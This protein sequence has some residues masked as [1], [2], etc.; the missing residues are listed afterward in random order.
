MLLTY[1]SVDNTLAFYDSMKEKKE[2]GGFPDFLAEYIQWIE[3]ILADYG[4][5]T[6]TLVYRYATCPQQ[7]DL[8]SCGICVA[9]CA[10]E[11]VAAVELREADKKPSRKRLT[12]R[13]NAM[14]VKRFS[15]TQLIQIRRDFFFMIID[16]PRIAVK[17]ALCTE[18][19]LFKLYLQ[20]K[21]RSIN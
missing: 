21:F 19:F 7:N 18:N 12:F 16:I 14:T 4:H 17:L 11:V 13:K 10:R 5:P 20:A 3:M 9:Y 1:T 2:S 6:D 15:K 8:S